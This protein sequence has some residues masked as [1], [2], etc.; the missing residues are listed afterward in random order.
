MKPA[1][2]GKDISWPA[3]AMTDFAP[4]RRFF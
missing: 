4:V 3:P 2:G 1:H